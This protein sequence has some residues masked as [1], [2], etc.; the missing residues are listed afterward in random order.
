[1]KKELDWRIFA[2][3]LTDL[4]KAEGQSHFLNQAFIFLNE[5]VVV[6]SCA[7]FKVA[8]DKTSGAEHL[9]TFGSLN[10]QTGTSAS[11]LRL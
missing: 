8:A 9:C 11:S 4:S 3:R 7:V 2:K 6:D 10:P 1:M 5:F